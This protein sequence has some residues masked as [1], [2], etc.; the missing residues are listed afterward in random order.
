MFT[1]ENLIRV[2]L[3]KEDNRSFH[4]GLHSTVYEPVSFKF[5]V[6]IDTTKLYSRKPV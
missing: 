2:I 6:I 3:S 5:C 4:T 1:L